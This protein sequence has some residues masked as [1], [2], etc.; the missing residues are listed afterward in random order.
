MDGK[1]SAAPQPGDF[2]NDI[3][4]T[5][6]KGLAALRRSEEARAR[7]KLTEEQNREF[8]TQFHKDL[9][10]RRIQSR[11]FR[12]EIH[13][14]TMGIFSRLKAGATEAPAAKAKTGKPPQE[15]KDAKHAKEQKKGG[16]KPNQMIANRTKEIAALTASGKTPLEIARILDAQK[17]LDGQ[18]K[19][20]VPDSW[21][22]VE[23]DGTPYLVKNFEK[24]YYDQHLRKKF[25]GL[26]YYSKKSCAEVVG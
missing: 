22:I 21:M 5:I 24:A 15:S 8:L 13:K 20:P 18:Q 19:Y 2:S 7:A 11:E 9:E 10:E 12:A 17:N 6:A 26:I 4:K 25:Y 1:K 14:V 3:D 16:R 23:D